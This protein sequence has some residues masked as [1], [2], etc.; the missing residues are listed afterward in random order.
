MSI[1]KLNYL[2][3][4]APNPD[5]ISIENNVIQEKITSKRGILSSIRKKL[6][7]ATKR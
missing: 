7:N 5:E 3:F 1:Y 2:N 6:Y 4:I